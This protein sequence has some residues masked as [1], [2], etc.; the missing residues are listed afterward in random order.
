M[1]LGEAL[2]NTRFSLIRGTLSGAGLD[3]ADLDRRVRD[4]ERTFRAGQYRSQL[5]VLARELE[6]FAGR[7]LIG[8]AKLRDAV[9]TI[10]ARMEAEVPELYA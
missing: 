8:G 10:T 9:Q 2:I 1:A 6:R 5:V 7:M 3:P 4:L